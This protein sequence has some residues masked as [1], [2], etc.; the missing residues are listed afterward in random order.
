M[1]RESAVSIACSTVP[2]QH[3]V[4]DSNCAMYIYT[5]GIQARVLELETLETTICGGDKVDLI[6][7]VFVDVSYRI[8]WLR[9]THV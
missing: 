5:D 7:Q 2:D 6:R 3:Q 8:T 9:M 4:Y 1:Q